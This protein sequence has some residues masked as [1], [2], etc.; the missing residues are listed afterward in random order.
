MWMLWASWWRWC[1]FVLKMAMPPFLLCGGNAAQYHHL[2]WCHKATYSPPP[3]SP[4]LHVILLWVLIFIICSDCCDCS[5]TRDTAA[6]HQDYSLLQQRIM[7]EMYKSLDFCRTN[8][9]LFFPMWAYLIATGLDCEKWTNFGYNDIITMTLC[10]YSDVKRR[11]GMHHIH[12]HVFPRNSGR[13]ESFL[14]QGCVQ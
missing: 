5:W 3:S 12:V 13:R 8:I 1:S 7:I 6:Y 14:A 11:N 10:T 2:H 4:L 9:I